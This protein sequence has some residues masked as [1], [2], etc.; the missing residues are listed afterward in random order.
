MQLSLV[1]TLPLHLLQ[2]EI[3]FP[4]RGHSSQ[5][6]RTFTDPVPPRHGQ[7][8][9]L[10]GFGNSA[11]HPLEAP[12]TSSASLHSFRAA[13]CSLLCAGTWHL[14]GTQQLLAPRTSSECCDRG[15]PEG[16]SI[17]GPGKSPELS[18]L[19]RLPNSRE[20]GSIPNIWLSLLLAHP[21]PTEDTHKALWGLH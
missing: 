8:A 4:F 11:L 9:Q 14:A 20:M 3:S 21:S 12:F 2:L 13:L 5:R 17:S 6:P 19:N 18:R 7:V 10:C 1:R 16:S 15:L